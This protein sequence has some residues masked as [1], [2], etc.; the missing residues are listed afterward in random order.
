[1]SL[2]KLNLNNSGKLVQKS[3]RFGSRHK[4]IIELSNTRI[5]QILIPKFETLVGRLH[6]ML[7]FLDFWSKN[8]YTKQSQLHPRLKSLPI[9]TNFTLISTNFSFNHK[10]HETSISFKIL[11]KFQ[12]FMDMLMTIQ[13]QIDLEPFNYSG[14]YL[15]IFFDFSRSII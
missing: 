7:R 14:F 5:Q 8:S 9:C 4:V 11:E 15:I 3:N 2:D 10:I 13:V 1:M 12:T 6:Q